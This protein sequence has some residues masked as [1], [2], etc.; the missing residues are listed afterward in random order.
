MRSIRHTLLLWLF[1]GLSLGMA[2]AAVL[3]Y[4]QAREEANQIFDYQMK[5]LAASLPSQPFAPVFPER[6]GGGDIERDI[7]IQMWDG[8]GVRIYHSHDMPS[9]PQRAELGFTNVHAGNGAWRVYSV[10]HGN[11]VVQVAQP[12]SARRELA[13]DTALRTVAPLLL[14]FP[15]LGILIWVTVGSG[16][17]PVRRVAAEV[18]A[19]GATALAPIPDA[20]LPQEI[21]PLTHALNDLLARLDQAIDA[22]RAFVADAAHELRTPLTA[23]KL[24]IQLAERAADD[25]ERR[26]AFAELKQGFER[27]THLVQQ[28]LTLARQEPGASQRVRRP[29]DLA[30]IARQALADFAPVAAAR[31]IDLGAGELPVAVVE[32]DPDALRILLNNLLDNAIRYTPEGGRVD[33]HLDCAGGAATLAVED[34]GPGIPPQELTRVFDRFYRVPGSGVQGSGLGLAIVRQVAD[35]HGARVRLENTGNGL[36]VSVVFAPAERHAGGRDA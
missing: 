22:Q 33:V 9:L 5:Q 23:L 13:A 31:R 11:T 16:L 7:V 18:E 19:R 29:V 10:Q 3:L 15:F 12:L 2:I 8:T 24:Q 6:G 4:F 30:D 20:D 32:G 1:A 27:A 25:G 36:R 17:S 21:R 14:L 34:S 26:A 35:A 28:L